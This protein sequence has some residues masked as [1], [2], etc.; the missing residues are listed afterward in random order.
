[1]LINLIILSFSFPELFFNMNPFSLNK[2]GFRRGRNSKY[3]SYSNKRIRLIERN[4]R[5]LVHKSVRLKESFGAI[6][7]KKK[8]SCALLNV[9]GLTDASLTDVKDVLFRKK[10]DLCVLLETKI[11]LE[12]EGPCLDVPGYDVSQRHRSDAAGDRGGG[13]IAIFTRKRDGL[14]F[15][16][17]DPDIENPAHVFVRTERAWTTVE[18]VS[19]K[20][21]VCAVYAGFQAPDD[22]HGEWNQNLYS[23]LKSEI[24]K[25]RTDGFRVVMLG[26]FNGHVG[27]DPTVGI[28]GNHAG[29]NRN[30]RR[31]L[32]FLA[33]AHCVHINGCPNLTRGLWTRQRGT[34]STILDYCVVGMEH[35]SSILS[36]SIDDHG[37]FGGGSDHNWVFLDMIDSFVRK[38]RISNL[39]K[40][41][42]PWNIT[43]TQDWSSFEATVDAMVDET[44]AAT[45]NDAA[46]ANRTTNILM[47]SGLTTIGLRNVSSKSSMKATSLP[48]I[49]VDEIKLKRQLEK[50]WKSKTSF[51]SSLPAPLR[52]DQLQQEVEEAERLFLDQ[53]AKVK[54]SFF[55]RGKARRARILEQCSQKSTEALKCFWSHINKSA[56]KSC[57]IDAVLSP[58]TGIL[59]CAPEEIALQVENHLVS[60]FNGS[61][62]PI[63]VGPVDNGHGH[64]DHAYAGEPGPA[65]ATSDPATDHP[66]SASASPRL[67]DSDGSTSIQTDPNGW[68]DKDFSLRD[69]ERAVKT[70][71]AGKAVGVD[72]V[73]NEF[74]IHAGVKFWKLLTILYNRVKKSGTFPPGWNQ[75]RVALVHKKGMR[76]LLG[77][78]RPLTVIISLSGLYSRLMNERLTSVVETYGLLGQIQN[79]FRRGRC[80]S[81]NS[82]LLSTILWKSKSARKKVHLAFIDLTKVWILS[83]YFCPTSMIVIFEI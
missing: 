50:T 7:T 83:Q 57:E 20:T 40:R 32:D 1:M 80:G 16:S 8:L 37:H 72:Y 25:L 74:L 52:T 62:E 60:V 54:E 6:G 18:S 39:P 64:G 51:Y 33:E 79:G 2:T 12:E 15:R 75:G 67:P 69:V 68:L 78:Y 81:D 9:D 11:R 26:D 38:L 34:V 63:P 76:E 41:K 45:M 23:V 66:Y 77:N 14:V 43:P 49:M 22:R 27:C 59:H 70:L 29:V 35:L 82:F 31:F 36:M 5:T 46:L 10:P 4:A 28:V 56:H 55:D 19:G 17:Y 47:Q 71:K 42:L 3:R 48:K 44:D 24:V 65:M 73:P 53:L 61:L 30:G 58:T 21:A 13:G